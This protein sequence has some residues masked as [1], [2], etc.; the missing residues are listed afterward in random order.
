MRRLISRNNYLNSK[1]LN[2][3]ENKVFNLHKKFKNKFGLD[4][5]EIL[6]GKSLLFNHEYEKANVELLKIEGKSEQAGTP[7][8]EAP[9]EIK[10]VKGVRNLF[11]VRDDAFGTQLVTYTKL[12]DNSIRISATRD[13]KTTWSGYV[14]VPIN[15]EN[16]KP[17]T[18]YTFSNKHK[19][20]GTTFNR[21]GAIRTKINGT[22]NTLYETDSITFTTPEDLQSLSLVFYIAHTD[23]TIGTGSIDFED[24]MLE[25]GSIRHSA[26][27]Y[28][29]W[30][31]VKDT[32]K[33]L[34]DGVLK[35]GTITNDT[36]IYY[37]ANNSIMG[38]QYISVKP[39]E[40]Y[41]ISTNGTYSIF[42][43]YY[44]K[45]KNYLGYDNIQKT[46]KT[47]TTTND[48]YFIRLRTRQAENITDLNS[49]IMLEKGST[50]TEYEDYKE[51]STLIDMNKPNLFDKDNANILNLYP[52]STFLSNTLYQSICI[53]IEPNTTYTLISLNHYSDGLVLGTSEEYPVA[54][55]M[56]TNK[57]SVPKTKNNITITSGENDK[58]LLAYI[59]WGTSIS[60]EILDGIKIYEGIG[61]DDYYELPSIGDTK[62]ILTIQNG[63]A[64]INQKIGKISSY[65]GETI[66]NTYISNTGELTTGSTVYYILEEPQTITLNGTYDIELFEG[67][68]NITTNDELS[69]SMEAKIHCLNPVETELRNIQIGD[70]L[71]DRV[72]HLNF[73]WESY[74]N[75]TNNEFVK[76]ITVDSE[77]DIQYKYNT[78][79][80]RR[81]I[82][83]HYEDDKTNY[84]LY[85]KYDSKINNDFNYIRYKLPNKIGKVID[86]DNT[87]TFYSC[88]KVKDDEYKLLEYQKKKWIDNEIPY[89]QYIDNIEEGI[90]NLAESLYKPL[91]YEYKNWT[92]T[93][94]YGI[95]SNDYGLAQ[96]PISNKD[97]DRWDRNIHLLENIIDSEINIWNIVSYTNWNESSQFEW[98]EY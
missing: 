82:A 73:P 90:N 40:T 31:E 34:F 6:S 88:I 81:Y 93:G 4:K 33:N 69:P 14:E 48:T 42:Y 3:I 72:L 17:N 98:E 53:S 59:K 35:L 50:A 38:E 70:V 13:S 79:N 55:G 30:L 91:G 27:P 52:G 51:Q 54:G 71:S 58:Y 9:V 45:N 78:N 95:G 67:T 36:G 60:E 12:T 41:T 32:G 87:N 19:I 29:S 57:L 64:T 46:P 83:Y 10:T 44:D 96:K 39:N 77:N 66:T 85:S 92:I 62:D 21:M 22:Y 1:M 65:N 26:V 37:S 11:K 5:Y 89:L 43:H 84:I 47:F 15:L 94:Y 24:I 74:K 16:I 18:T 25:E 68:N 63:Q 28:G 97:F 75:I 56:T 8:P 2:D 7:T 61:T 49:K 86:I 80:L 76:I 23:S 20:E